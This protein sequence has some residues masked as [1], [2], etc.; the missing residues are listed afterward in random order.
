MIGI[1]FKAIEID[2]LG[3]EN[4]IASSARVSISNFEAVLWHEQ[5]I[6]RRWMI[7]G[8]ERSLSGISPRFPDA[9]LEAERLYYKLGGRARRVVITNRAGAQ[10]LY[11]AQNIRPDLNETK[12]QYL[13]RVNEAILS[14]CDKATAVFP[15]PSLDRG[16]VGYA[17]M[18]KFTLDNLENGGCLALAVFDGKKLH[19]SFVVHFSSGQ[20]ELVTSFERWNGLRESVSFSA[21][22]LSQVQNLIQTDLG[23]VACAAFL[24]RQ[25]F[26]RLFDGNRKT[27]LPRSFKLGQTGFA[28]TP[29]QNE[30]A[31]ALE[32]KILHTA[33]ILAYIPAWIN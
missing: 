12:F 21:E 3:Y 2:P 16:P 32:K 27:R 20:A 22:S 10:K 18:E 5:G 28:C 33:G 11:A 14:A 31:S 6:N 8:R 7:G 19:F 30:K 25:D 23:P 13:Q 24:S 17:A 26:E 1:N 4:F 29:V 9:S 15:Q